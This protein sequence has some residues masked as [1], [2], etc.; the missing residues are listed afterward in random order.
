MKTGDVVFVNDGS[1][2]VELTKEGL[3]HNL[4][5][6]ERYVSWRVLQTNL[7]LPGETF[8]GKEHINDTILQGQN[9][10]ERIVFVQERFLK[11]RNC[12]TCGKEDS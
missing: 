11:Y 9:N 8:L 3:K 4:I 5:G 6:M 1:Y 12:P 10:P 7:T 2:S